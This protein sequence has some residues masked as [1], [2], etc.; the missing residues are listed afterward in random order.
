MK[1]TIK[2]AALVCAMIPAASM[3]ATVNLDL[4]AVQPEMSSTRTI[5]DTVNDMDVTISSVGRAGGLTFGAQGLGVIGGEGSNAAVRINAGEIVRFDFGRLVR[6]LRVSVGAVNGEA[7][8]SYT[9]VGA[10][11]LTEEILPGAFVRSDKPE[12]IGGIH[13]N[14]ISMSGGGP[15]AAL[16]VTTTATSSTAGFSV[17][18]IY[19]DAIEPAASIAPV[20]LPAAGML[21]GGGIAVLAWL[22]C[23]KRTPA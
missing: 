2:A 9:L 1:L 7:G 13:W 23:R 5:T 18:S 19:Y 8:R 15:I 21:L 11:G 14:A 20:P 4:T 10:D 3:A 6:D 22:G 12:R 16:L 17:R